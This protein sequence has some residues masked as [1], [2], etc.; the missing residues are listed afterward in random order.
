[1]NR[2]L[3]MAVALL[4]ASTCS[5]QTRASS[6]WL[7]IH[8]VT[9]IDDTGAPAAAHRRVIVHGNRIVGIVSSA[10]LEKT[11]QTPAGTWI[12]GWENS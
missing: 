10:E 3:A 4:L 1:M 12:D 11:S 5:G 9:V 7:Y 8:D 2:M 6:P